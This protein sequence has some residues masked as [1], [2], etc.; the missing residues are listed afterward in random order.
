MP[1]FSRLLVPLGFATLTRLD[2][3]GQSRSSSW[4]DPGMVMLGGISVVIPGVQCGDARG[5]GGTSVVMLG[6]LAWWCWGVLVW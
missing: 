3:G 6:V 2:G 4:G 5:T 1:F